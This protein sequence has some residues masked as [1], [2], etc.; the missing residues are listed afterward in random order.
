MQV[1]S[2]VKF[3]SLTFDQS[4]ARGRNLWHS[5][6]AAERTVLLRDGALARVEREN[7]WLRGEYQALR[8]RL[9]SQEV[10]F[11][12]IA[13][14]SRRDVEFLSHILTRPSIP[15]VTHAVCVHIDSCMC[16][17]CLTFSP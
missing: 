2:T 3:G 8:K 16:N 6:K 4:C 1:H 14:V 17:S 13:G 10:D 9:A 5:L 15:Q 12:A 11:E 7:V